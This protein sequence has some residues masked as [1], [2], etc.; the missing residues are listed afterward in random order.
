MELMEENPMNTT[1]PIREFLD[2]FISWASQQPDVQGVALVGSYARG[3][4]RD[5]S[6]IDLVILTEQPQTY[7]DDISWIE[8]FGIP[9]KH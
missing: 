1:Q 4:A 9:E 3:A 5:D 7:L 6:D 2:E 8:R